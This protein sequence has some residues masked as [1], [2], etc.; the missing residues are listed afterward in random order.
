[1][2]KK[3]WKVTRPEVDPVTPVTPWGGNEK[4]AKI[5]DFTFEKSVNF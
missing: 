4:S 1:M 3:T 5:S 2:E